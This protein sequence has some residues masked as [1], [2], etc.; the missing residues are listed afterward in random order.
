[1]WLKASLNGG[2]APGEHPALP[3]TPQDLADDARAVAAQ[4]ASAVH[5][6][7]RDAGGLET[8][9]APAVGAA[10]SA[11]RRA[12]PGLPVGVSTGLWITGGD[13]EARLSA[14]R[15][16]AP[17]PDEERPD[18]AS[19]NVSE[20][21]FHDL[22]VAVLESGVGV[23]AG[24][25]SRDDAEELAAS[26]LAGRVMRVLVEI[27]DASAEDAV[28][29][30]ARVLDRLDALGLTAPRLLHGE[31]AAAWPLLEEAV[32]RGLPGRMGLEDVLHGPSGE[33][34]SGNAELVRL[35]LARSAQG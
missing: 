2:R 3:L 33:P 10:V 22:A 23:E 17:L 25:W 12:V 1:M 16:W 14:V 4:G 26:G 30:A 35:A 32:R 18:F 5:A 13:V 6:H 15:A 34:V 7:P 29:E 24:V 28:P 27:M 21:G 20:P 8:L 9:A 11:I 19:C 31:G